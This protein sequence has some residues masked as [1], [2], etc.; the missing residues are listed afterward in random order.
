MIGWAV[1]FL[2]VYIQALLPTPGRIEVGG[3]DEGDCD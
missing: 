3:S 1:F 2:L